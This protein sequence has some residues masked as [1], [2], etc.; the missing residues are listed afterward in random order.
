MSEWYCTF[1]YPPNW[2]E[3]LHTPDGP[4]PGMDQT[5]L[6][7]RIQAAVDRSFPSE[8][9]EK[10]E[11][12][13]AVV[14]PQIA[15]DAARDAAVSAHGYDLDEQGFG[16]HM[17]L[18]MW[19]AE[20]RRPDSLDEELALLADTVREAGA[21]VEAP[22]VT[23]VTL[24]AAGRALRVQQLDNGHVSSGTTSAVQALDYWLPVQSSVDMLWI[25]FWTPHLASSDDAV[26]LFD[27][28]ARALVVEPA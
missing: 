28:I 27:Q 21:N 4:G 5:G 20:R 18:T 24:P 3:V 10:R 25:H 22:E 16:V 2:I 23:E 11:R 8:P 14:V 7:E 15:E 1:H 13:A 17:H 6:G 26:A 19:V 12:L 9:S